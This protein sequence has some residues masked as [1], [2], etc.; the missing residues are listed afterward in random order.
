L[1]DRL[2]GGRH[3]RAVKIVT[4]AA[5]DHAAELD[6]DIGTG[7]QL[8]HRALPIGEEFVAPSGVGAVSERTADMPHDDRRRRKGARQVD[9][10]G[11]LRVVEP[12]VE[13]EPERREPLEPGAEIRPPIKL[14]SGIGAG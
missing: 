11:E 9:D 8:A 2:G 13:A 5:V 3:W 1:S 14:W 10:I 6:D 12:G 7:G 4:S